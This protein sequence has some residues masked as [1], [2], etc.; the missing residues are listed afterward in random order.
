MDK[1]NSEG[2]GGPTT[3]MTK[4]DADVRKRFTQIQVKIELFLLLYF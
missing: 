2:E 3:K 4:S 1:E